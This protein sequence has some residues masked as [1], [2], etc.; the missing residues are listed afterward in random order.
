MNLDHRGWRAASHPSSHCPE[1]S[2]PSLLP[3]M[4]PKTPTLRPHRCER[5]MVSRNQPSGN[6]VRLLVRILTTRDLHHHPR[7]HRSLHRTTRATPV[8]RT[9]TINPIY[10]MFPLHTTHPKPIARWTSLRRDRSLR[11]TFGWS[12]TTDTV[13]ATTVDLGTHP[14]SYAGR[15]AS[16]KRSARGRA[17][18][19]GKSSGISIVIGNG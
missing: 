3:T 2:P 1:R 5:S 18:G 10:S 19:S 7:R 9:P 12:K 8:Q 17:I 6:L 16:A 13:S 14:T 4:S 11:V 15:C